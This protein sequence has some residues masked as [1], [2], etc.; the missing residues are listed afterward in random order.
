MNGLDM[1]ERNGGATD[2]RQASTFNPSTPDVTGRDL[3]PKNGRGHGP[4]SHAS[5][6][7]RA[8]EGVPPQHF[9][10]GRPP[11]EMAGQAPYASSDCHAHLTH[12]SGFQPAW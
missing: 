3:E 5:R 12:G 11:D 7:Y 6:G 9:W 10:P 4:G 1:G 8:M 2:K